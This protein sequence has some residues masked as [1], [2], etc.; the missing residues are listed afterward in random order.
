MKGEKSK[1]LLIDDEPDILDFL[2]YSFEKEGYIIYTAS[3]GFKGEKIALEINPDMIILD[4]MM[5]GMDGIELCNKLKDNL[6]FKDTLIVLLTARGEDYSQIAGFD[7]GADDYVTKPVKP[8]V[9]LARVKALLKRNNKEPE[10]INVI[11]LKDIKIDIEKR[12]VIFDNRE[13]FLPKI[14]FNILLLF[15]SN[16]GRVFVREEIYSRI[17][18]N[19]IYVGDRTLD[20]HIRKLRKK[21]DKK[22]IK[23]IKGIGYG[24]SV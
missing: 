7:A 2:K 5:P 8:K 15:A 24:I 10:N 9:L 18:G 16:P 11:E 22:V 17:W 3:N 20:V 1:I 13:I 14:E 6:Q 19:D 21:L 12:V 23:T 4:I